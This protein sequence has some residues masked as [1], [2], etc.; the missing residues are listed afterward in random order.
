[1][2][3]G[4]LTAAA[5]ACSASVQDHMVRAITEIVQNGAEAIIKARDAGLG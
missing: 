3:S 4:L 5:L 2:V 1:M